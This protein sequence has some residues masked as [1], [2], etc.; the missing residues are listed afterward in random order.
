MSVTKLILNSVPRPWLIRLSYFVR[1]LLIWLYRGNQVTDPI[2]QRSFRRFL[3]YG[4][5]QLRKGVLS[6]ST[7]S[8]ERHR[9]LWLY[10]NKETTLLQNSAKIELLHIAPEQCFYSIFKKRENF[11]YTTF[12]LNSPLAEIHGDITKL[13]FKENT[14]DYILCNHVLEHIEN[15]DLAMKE[16]FRVMKSGGYGIVQVPMQPNRLETYEDFS[17]THAEERVKHF[18]QYDHVR[19]YGRDD[20]FTRLENVGFTTQKIKVNEFFSKE[21]INRYGLDVNEIIPV[22]QKPQ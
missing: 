18:G 6:P 15:D 11:N 13:P 14:F 22:I 3:P 16:L 21:E 8:L 19:W 5:N 4:Y 9:A 1:P 20:Y 17:I 12:D 7:L 10:L 2:D